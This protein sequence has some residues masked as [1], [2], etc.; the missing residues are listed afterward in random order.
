MILKDI[1]NYRP[2]LLEKLVSIRLRT[3]PSVY[4]KGPKW[5]G[6]TYLCR[7][8]ANSEINLLVDNNKE[9]AELNSDY[10]FD[11]DKPRLIDEWQECP[12]LWDKIKTKSDQ[13][14]QFLLTGSV[15]LLNRENIHHSGVGR[16]DKLF[17]RPCSLYETGYSSGTISL[18][19]FLLNPNCSIGKHSSLSFNDLINCICI[20]GWPYQFNLENIEDKLILPK[21]YINSIIDDESKL[22]NPRQ[23][24][25]TRIFLKSISRNVQC[26]TKDETILQDYLSFENTSNRNEYFKLKKIFFDQYILDYTDCWNPNIRSKTSIRTSS[27]ISLVDP[28]IAVASLD[29]SPEDLRHDFNTLGYLFE[30]LVSRDIKVYMSIN[31]GSVYYYRDRLGLECDLVVKDNKGRIAL[32]EVKLGSKGIDEGSK[33]LLKIDK[34]IRVSD[35]EGRTHNLIPSALAVITSTDFAYK[36]DDGVYV[37]PIGCLRD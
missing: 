35:K 11:G 30:N 5:C 36:R 7:K 17:L 33:N 3:F 13:P 18:K 32:L 4:I 2:R 10:I 16:I 25:R 9:L 31:D 37:I 28:S 20:G 12:S 23:K 14:S 29:L 22:L 27:K 8:L 1:D 19:E 24:D 15:N 21:S 34:L 26:T 6:K